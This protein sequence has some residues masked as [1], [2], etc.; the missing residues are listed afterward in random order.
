MNGKNSIFSDFCAPR[1]F[2]QGSLSNPD[3]TKLRL[4][5]FQNFGTGYPRL[6]NVGYPGKTKVYFPDAG[7]YAYIEE[8]ERGVLNEYTTS[9]GEN[10]IN[11]CMKFYTPQTKFYESLPIY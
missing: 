3:G 2:S 7:M 8:R 9:F 11:A 5:L 10:K 4:P 6:K 1:H